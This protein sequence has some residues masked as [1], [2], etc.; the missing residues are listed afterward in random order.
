MRLLAFE[1]GS[2]LRRL[3]IEWSAARRM[4]HPLR[5]SGVCY[6]EHG[7]KLEKLF[8]SGMCLKQK[9]GR[10][11]GCRLGSEKGPRRMLHEFHLSAA[12]C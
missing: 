12:T 4:N 11:L 6:E 7:H 1:I 2:A 8:R 5:S 3:R 9:P 10:A